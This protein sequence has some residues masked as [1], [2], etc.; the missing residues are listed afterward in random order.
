MRRQL[1]CLKRNKANFLLLLLFAAPFFAWTQSTKE[2]KGVVKDDKGAGIPGVTITVKGKGRSKASDASGAFGIQATE[3]ETLVFSAVG[4]SPV[5]VPVT[6][7]NYY[8]VA[9]S[10]AANTL[11]DVV[12]VGYGSSSRRALTSSITT[13]KPENLNRGAIH[14]RPVNEH[15]RGLDIRARRPQHHGRLRQR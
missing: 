15:V 6:R 11:S 9:M 7:E 2:I 5:E 1:D 14:R 3:G 4:Y 10:T 8:A 12:I 13:V